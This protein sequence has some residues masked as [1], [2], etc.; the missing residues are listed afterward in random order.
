MK[1][2]F[3][4]FVTALVIG[5]PFLSTLSVAQ[6]QPNRATNSRPNDPAI[7]DPSGRVVPRARSYSRGT[8]S[9]I[10]EEQRYR[11]DRALGE[12]EARATRR[13]E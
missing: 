8:N 5:T 1:K 13:R 11:L 2:F 10:T 7:R 3:P 6:T 12:A 9:T 4:I